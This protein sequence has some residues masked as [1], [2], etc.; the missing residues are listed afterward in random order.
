MVHVSPKNTFPLTSTGGVDKKTLTQNFGPYVRGIARQV[1]GTLSSQIEIDDLVNYGMIGLFEAADRFKPEIGANFTTFSY[2]R[3]RGAIYDGLRGMGWLRRSEYQKTKMSQRANSYLESVNTQMPLDASKKNATQA[4]GEVTEQVNNLV[5]IF[6][7][8][9]DAMTDVDFEDK[10]TKRQDDAFEEQQMQEL[11]LDALM[12][13][14][15]EDR[16]LIQL[17]YFDELSLEEVGKK[18]GLSKS[19]TCRKH[20]QAIGKLSKYLNQALAIRSVG[21]G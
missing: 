1:K 5:T 2:Y 14:N 13:L 8:S 4:L 18:I 6:I 12:N 17:Y 11:V 9:L 3:I 20:A 16:E 7:T 21:R 10:G 15:P 19:W